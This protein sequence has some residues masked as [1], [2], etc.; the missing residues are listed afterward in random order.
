M[1]DINENGMKNASI[2]STMM[3]KSWSEN[4]V[5]LLNVIILQLAESALV[6]AARVV[7]GVG[8][9]KF[10]SASK[11]TDCTTGSAPFALTF[12]RLI[13]FV[14]IELV[15]ISQNK[16]LGLIVGGF[17]SAIISVTD[18]SSRISVRLDP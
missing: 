2:V 7:V 16:C 3:T 1:Y 10:S 6:L 11:D 8:V 18:F 9:G 14:L 17:S 13:V 15:E 4:L 5:Y 12:C